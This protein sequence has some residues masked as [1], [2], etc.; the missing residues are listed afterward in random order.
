MIK[1]V[2]FLFLLSFLLV[3]V[4]H[5]QPA[6]AFEDRPFPVNSTVARFFLPEERTMAFDDFSET[7]M[8]ADTA[9]SPRVLMFNYCVYDSAYSG[10]LAR[11]IQRRYLD[12]SIDEFT[13]GT[14]VDLG[15][16]LRDYDAVVVGYPSV[17]NPT[18]LKAY[19][20]TLKKF[21]QQGGTVI[22][23][24]THEYATLQQLGLFD[25]DFGYYCTGTAVR[26]LQNTHPLLSGIA[27]SFIPDD[28]AY[29]LDISDPA[30]VALADVRGYPVA[31]YKIYGNGKV[32]YLG[33]EYYHDETE[34]SALLYNALRWAM[35]PPAISQASALPA[36]AVRRQ[37]EIL[38]TGSGNKSPRISM[39][40]Y[41]NPYYEKG[42]LD[43]ELDKSL[44]VNLFITD[45]LGRVTNVLLPR[46]VLNPGLYRFEMPNL[47]T[48]IYFVR[49]TV[50]DKTEVK[51]V[52]K[53]QA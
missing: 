7:P 50:G 24:G 48:G 40:I 44:P 49:C 25:I 31:G 22:V 36:R 20:A 42:T 43:L 5:R 53:K 1:P 13:A 28:Y 34:S 30:F 12:S 39:N 47:P 19:G 45:E 14:A 37:E 52:I 23:T 32:V 51:K 16:V 21:A 33:L 15:N 9:S 11:L 26:S 41:P 17:G 10:K 38:V 4:A 27:P 8:V 18:N 6:T 2:T 46:R 3:A 35:P 29:P